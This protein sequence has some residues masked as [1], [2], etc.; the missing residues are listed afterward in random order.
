MNFV[1]NFEA[2]NGTI[3]NLKIVTKFVQYF[4]INSW[5]ISFID[6]LWIYDPQSMTLKNRRR[7]WQFQSS[8]WDN[9]IS[10]SEYVSIHHSSGL[11]LTVSSDELVNLDVFLDD[12]DDQFWTLGPENEEGY[13][14]IQNLK[15]RKYL[16]AAGLTTTIWMV[17]LF[18]SYIL[19]K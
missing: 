9:F 17:N 15:S 19:V 1:Y 7:V 10:A 8:K 6:Q 2:E 5:N 13:F 14:T 12:S 3:F 11:V 4:K 16:T 18:L